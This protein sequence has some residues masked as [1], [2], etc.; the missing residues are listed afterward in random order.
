MEKIFF[1]QSTRKKP[2]AILNDYVYNFD[3]VKDQK[4]RW[5]CKVRT[6]QGAIFTSDAGNMLSFKPHNHD[7]IKNQK[8][9]LELKNIIKHKATST[10]ENYVDIIAEE[11][12]NLTNELCGEIV[13]RMNTIR[14]NVARLRNKNINYIPKDYDDFP[15]YLKVTMQNKAFLRYDSGINDPKD[16]YFLFR[17]GL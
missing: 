13:P 1:T 2:I 10:N 12:K 11:T 14:D 15:D 7:P 3:Y 4:T 5:R 8:E 17:Y 6:C 16:S 9:K